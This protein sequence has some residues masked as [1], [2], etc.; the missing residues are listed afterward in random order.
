MKKLKVVALSAALVA[1]LIAIP[2][3]A[4]ADDGSVGA[5]YLTIKSAKFIKKYLHKFIL[6]K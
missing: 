3:Q 4:S 1:G 6:T 5:L 2:S